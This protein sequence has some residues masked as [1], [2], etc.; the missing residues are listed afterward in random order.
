MVHISQDLDHK[1]ESLEKAPLLLTRFTKC[2]SQPQLSN[3][4][5]VDA[6]VQNRKFCLYLF[7]LSLCVFIYL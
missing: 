1:E 5:S 4:F 6:P 3:P 7:L 2:L